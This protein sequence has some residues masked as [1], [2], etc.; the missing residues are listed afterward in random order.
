MA[1]PPRP[2]TPSTTGPTPWPAARQRLPAAGNSYTATTCN[3]V[4]TGPTAGGHLYAGD[5]CGRQRLYGGTT[6]STATTGPTGV[7]RRVR[8]WPPASGNSYTATTCNTVTT[9]PT[10]V[11]SCTPATAVCRQ[12]LY[13]DDLQHRDQRTHRRGV[14]YACDR[15]FRQQLYGDD[16]QH[17]DHR[18]HCRR[19]V[20]ARDRGFR[21]PTIR[22]QPVPPPPPGPPACSHAVR[23]CGR[24]S[25]NSYTATTCNT[26]TTGPTGVSSCTPVRR[27]LPATTIRR[28]PATP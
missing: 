22:R 1:I 17:R 24:S 27:P 28:R 19:D 4:T 11:A 18:A 6:C 16:L 10:G 23:R 2:A 26:V 12:Q 8:Q 13:G 25:G 3:T 21:Q 20:Y 14:V 9:G 15:L 7:S 5:R